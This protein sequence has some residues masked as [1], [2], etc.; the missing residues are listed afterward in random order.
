MN[1]YAK[2]LKQKLFCLCLAGL[3]FSCGTYPPGS[4]PVWTVGAHG[5]TARSET[6]QP[7][8]RPEIAR[9]P[10]GEAESGF[11]IPEYIMGRGF[12]SAQKK[13][14]FLLNGN[15][16]A[17][18]DFVHSLAVIYLEEAALE[19]VNS[20]IAFAQMI[21]ETGFLRFGNLVT[22]QM[23]N[24]AGLGSIGPGQHGLW[25]PD[26]RTGVR[27]HIQHLKAYA[28]TAPLNQPLVNPRFRFV[29]RGSSP[30][31]GGLAGTWAA[32]PLYA[33]K[34]RDILRRMY[35]FADFVI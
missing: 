7:A 26:A 9:L 21:L 25:F 14:A 15:P 27:A 29:R 35:T 28:S 8:A 10:G 2:N 23:N 12:L 34:I 3:L 24:F 31:I 33:H 4:V 17:D 18:R 13:A 32:D 20:D 11:H 19:G 5:E 1:E 16:G 22:P 6:A 30:T